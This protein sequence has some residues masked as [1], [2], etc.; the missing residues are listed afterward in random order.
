M[1]E[2]SYVTRLRKAKCTMGTMENYPPI[3]AAI[4]GIIDDIGK[5]V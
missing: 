4:V 3:D 1:S 2:K 5:L